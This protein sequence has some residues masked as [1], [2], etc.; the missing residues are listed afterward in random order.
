MNRCTA[1]SMRIFLKSSCY[2]TG[3]SNMVRRAERRH[4]SAGWRNTVQEIKAS[5][6][7]N[8]EHKA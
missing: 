2:V 6:G 4:Q 5:L 7:L 1:Q 8:T 3:S